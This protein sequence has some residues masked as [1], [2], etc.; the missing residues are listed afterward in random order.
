MIEMFQKNHHLCNGGTNRGHSV[1]VPHLVNDLRH[2]FVTV[3]IIIIALWYKVLITQSLTKRFD[4][5][6]DRELAL[7]NQLAGVGPLRVQ[8]R[9]HIHQ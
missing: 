6:L 4:N 1:T 3:T 5:H 2:Q 7:A 8:T 9:T